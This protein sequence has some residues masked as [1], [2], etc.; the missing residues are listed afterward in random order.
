MPDKIDPNEIPEVAEFLRVK[1]ELDN[2]KAQ[3]APVFEGLEEIVRE[4]N[5]KLSAAEQVVRARQV[6]CGPFDAYQTQTKYDANALY[7]MMGRDKFLALG[8]QE[9]LQKVRS[10]DKKRVDM[11]IAA[12]NIPKEVADEVR[13]TTPKYK[14]PEKVTL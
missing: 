12:G 2:Y 9:E 7:E 14:T 11:N 3:H 4:Y 8:G 1:Q 10:L 5:D 6:S 13:K